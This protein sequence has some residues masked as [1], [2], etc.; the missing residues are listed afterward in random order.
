MHLP[1]LILAGLCP[2]LTAASAP[3]SLQVETPRQEDETPALVELDFESA[4]SRAER[5]EKFLVI[6]WVKGPD[7]PAGTR[8]R[9][10]IFGDKG[11]QQ[12]IDENAVAVRI[13]A[14]L[15]KDGA[16]RNPLRRYPCVDILDFVR[17]GR[18]G[19]ITVEDSSADFLATVYGATA[20][21]ASVE[22]PEG[23]AAKEPFRWLAWA[24]TRFRAV[25]P[26]GR[27]DAVNGYTWCLRRADDFRPGFRN[28]YLEFLL[29]RISSAKMQ[30][31]EAV[32]IL[33]AEAGLLAE[34]L[35]AGT[36][37]RQTAY[38]LVRVNNWRRKELETRDF[39]I[40]L[41]GRGPMQ[42]K[43]RRWLLPAAAPVLGRYQQYDE[44]LAEVRDE[45]TV[46]FA[47]RI[48][49][50]NAASG[51]APIPTEGG[52]AAPVKIVEPLP[53]SVPDSRMQIIEQASWVYEA[54]LAG[55][56]GSD[57][58]ELFELMVGA[59]PVSKTFG[60]FMERAL[61][62]ELWQLTAEI[63]DIGMGTLDARG[64]KRMQRLLQRIPE[65]TGDQ[66]GGDA[67]R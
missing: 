58:R 25:E 45:A 37:T 55:G 16:R 63:G 4:V 62:L 31:P 9:E 56:R 38:D 12:W 13:D 17:G 28:R 33:K 21:S 57:A 34:Q 18:V 41:G 29:E 44:I 61:R 26:Q 60:L 48:A 5:M 30:A 10:A 1:H 59:Y 64:Q 36:G 39:F 2:L 7:S 6:L 40:E 51:K 11:V 19:R 8:F 53:Y 42:D 24:N 20:E 66:G 49:S 35:R 52:D 65:P 27:K 23:E 15:D 50:L 22:K 3:P 46:I 54:L 32:D 47:S 67:D 14:E 43:A